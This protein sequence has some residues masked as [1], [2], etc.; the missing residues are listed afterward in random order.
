MSETQAAMPEEPEE[1]APPQ[2][3]LVPRDTSFEHALDETAPKPEPVH[4][5]DGHAI[6]A[7]GGDRRPVVPEHLQT[8][9]GISSTAGKYADA[10]Q[11]HASYHVLRSPGYLV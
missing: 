6:P 1:T 11:F 7:L 5:G 4:E 8:W 2:L 3:H 10:A 9:Q